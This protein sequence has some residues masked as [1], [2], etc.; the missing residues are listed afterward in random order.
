[1]RLWVKEKVDDSREAYIEIEE[2][3]MTASEL[4]KLAATKGAGFDDSPLVR[5]LSSPE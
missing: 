3:L 4:A 2:E 5:E 1:M